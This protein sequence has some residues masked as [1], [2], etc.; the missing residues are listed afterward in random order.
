MVELAPEPGV[1]V[2]QFFH[3]WRDLSPKDRAAI[4]DVLS[5]ERCRQLEELIADAETA[6]AVADR[7]F[8]VYSGW[9]GLLVEKAVNGN[10]Q[11][12]G[13]S[14]AITPA[15]WHALQNAHRRV[16]ADAAEVSSLQ[17]MIARLR[18]IVSSWVERI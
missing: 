12:D 2:L 17:M 16:I 11:N 15:V 13:E 9:L 5:E 6:E 18:H 7:Q 10:H 4:L 8:T 14:G 1:E 3:R